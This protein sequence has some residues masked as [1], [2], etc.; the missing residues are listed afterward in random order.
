MFHSQLSN[1]DVWAV[2]A[3]TKMCPE[4]LETTEETAQQF[5]LLLVVFQCSSV[6]HYLR[7]SHGK[8]RRFSHLSPNLSPALRQ[9]FLEVDILRYELGFNDT[10]LTDSMVWL[11][12]ACRYRTVAHQSSETHCPLPFAPPSLLGEAIVVKETLNPSGLLYLCPTGCCPTLHLK[13]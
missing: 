10:S 13:T 11:G 6:F 12:G 1:K 2:V 5:R 4:N 9:I 3:Y 8:A 7:T